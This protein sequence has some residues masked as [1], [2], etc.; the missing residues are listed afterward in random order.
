VY[1]KIKDFPVR[2]FNNNKK[3]H[4]LLSQKNIS[5]PERHIIIPLYVI[6]CNQRE[7]LATK[8]ITFIQTL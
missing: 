1:E 5:K 8:E 4:E 6:I 7:G 2:T 3:S